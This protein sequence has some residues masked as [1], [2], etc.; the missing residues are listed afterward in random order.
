MVIN[1]W[2][3]INNMLCLVLGNSWPKLFCFSFIMIV[4]WI[5]LN[6]MIAFMLE[7]HG[8]VS[9]EVEKEWKR[10]DWL[11]NLKEGWS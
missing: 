7:I 11:R 1:N 6:L 8:N 4:V 10:R 9:E 5:M 2:Y 3:V